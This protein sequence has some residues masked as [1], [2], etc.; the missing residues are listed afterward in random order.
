MC[1]LKGAC[2]VKWKSALYGILWCVK[3][4]LVPGVDRVFV[5]LVSALSKFEGDGMG[6]VGG[7]I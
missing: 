7:G 4:N 1:E 2:V 6:K 5:W 3:L